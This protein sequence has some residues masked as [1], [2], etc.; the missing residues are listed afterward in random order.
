MSGKV[1]AVHFKDAKKDRIQEILT[2]VEQGNKRLLINIDC[3]AIMY[4]LYVTYM[5]NE[6][7]PTAFNLPSFRCIHQ[8]KKYFISTSCYFGLK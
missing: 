7:H 2:L 5:E 4:F 8:R 6:W 1:T 3:N